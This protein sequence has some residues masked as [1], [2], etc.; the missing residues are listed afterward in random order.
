MI[1]TFAGHH[2]P[3]RP[4]GNPG[5]DQTLG[6]IGH[7]IK[8]CDENHPK[9]QYTISGMPIE[10]T[11]KLPTRVLDVGS[12]EDNIRL[13]V[14]GNQQAKYIALSH[15]WGGISQIRTTNSSLEEHI[16]YINFN[17]LSKTIQDAIY[18]TRNLGIQ[19][20]WVDSLCIIQYDERDW[21][22]EARKM[23]Y[24]YERAYCTIA[25]TSASDGTEGCL[26]PRPPQDLVKVQCQQ[27]DARSGHM[28]FGIKDD[29]AVHRMFEG[30]LNNR[31]WVLQEHLH[32][33][34]T[35]HFASDQ[36]Y[37][38]CEK[39]FVAEDGSDARGHVDVKTI[40]TRSLFCYVLHGYLGPERI[41]DVLFARRVADD[42]TEPRDFHSIWAQIIKYYTRCGLTESS[43]KLPAILSLSNELQ[44]LTGHEYHE[45]HWFDGTPFVFSSLLWRAGKDNTLRKPPRY[46]APSWSWA[47]LDGPLDFADLT[48]WYIDLFHPRT[49][50]LHILRVGSYHPVG[51]PPCKALLLSGH[52][53]RGFGCTTG[54]KKSNIQARGSSDCGEC[55]AGRLGNS[56]TV[57]SEYGKEIRGS[58]QYDLSHATP[59]NF[60]LLPFYVRFIRK[61]LSEPVYFALIVSEV[62]NQKFYGYVFQRIGIGHIDDPM[63]ANG[64]PRRFLAL[65]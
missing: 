53:I 38:E 36:V 54:V 60:W 46:R 7:W 8:T 1:G 23:A 32:S 9:C 16:R 24:I 20:L 14:T 25:A 61:G 49:T 65:I 17:N 35:I 40:P 63:W 41:P 37:W 29:S 4:V 18:L 12:C 26:I 30:P 43:D 45:G 48:M 56:A 5:S 22:E 42:F 62:P 13:L 6:V 59:S 2:I 11:P 34:R 31:A 58:F 28:Y 10:L 19:Y 55:E 27:G 21:L 47:A 15:C 64:Y 57:F 51:M 50:D 39:K 52:L 44:E 3:Y 33:R